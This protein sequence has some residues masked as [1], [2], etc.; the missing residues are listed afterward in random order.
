MSLWTMYSSTISM[1]ST[2]RSY[3]NGV[4]HLHSMFSSPQRGLNS[5][6]LLLSLDFERHVPGLVGP[7]AP[8]RSASRPSTFLVFSSLRS[9]GLSPS[10]ATRACRTS[11]AAPLGVR[12]WRVP[13][14]PSHDMLTHVSGLSPGTPSIASTFKLLCQVPSIF[15]V[16]VLFSNSAPMTFTTASASI[17]S[18]SFTKASSISFV[19]MLGQQRFLLSLDL[20]IW[21]GLSLVVHAGLPHSAHGARTDF[22]WH[23][24]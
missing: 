18:P 3:R 7:P 2:I 5:A 10:P 6:V 11:L 20:L 15:F 19:T 16:S 24:R 12:T 13:S 23:S 1:P 8:P 21:S 22:S 17:T 4:D 14:A 9:L